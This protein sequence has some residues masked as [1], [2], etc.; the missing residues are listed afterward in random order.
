MIRPD[1]STTMRIWHPALYPRLCTKHLVA[2]WREGLGAYKVI[3][4][5]L[6]GYSNHPAVLEYKGCPQRLWYRLSL[7]RE[8]MLRRGYHPK[9][10]PALVV[11]NGEFVEWESLEDQVRKLQAKHCPCHV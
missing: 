1:N 7:I 4:L 10:L 11:K 3:T 6:K 2:C 8:E 9:D 5:E